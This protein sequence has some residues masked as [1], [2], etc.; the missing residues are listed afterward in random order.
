[1]KRLLIAVLISLLLP[2]I[3]YAD[4]TVKIAEPSHRGADGLFLDNQL[5][6]LVRAQGELRKLIRTSSASLVV[7]IATLEEIA[8]LADGYSYLNDA[9]ERVEVEKLTA[10]TNL[11]R[12]ISR[13]TKD[14]ETLILPYGNPDVDLFEN[15]PKDLEFYQQIAL[16]KASN[17]FTNFKLAPLV[18]DGVVSELPQSFYTTYRKELRALNVATTDPQVVTLRSELAKVL[19]PDLS[20]ASAGVLMSTLRY[21]IRE[22]EKRLRIVAGNYTI[23]ASKYDLPITVINEF[24][25]PITTELSVRSSNSR[26]RIGNVEPL[27]I[28]P[29]S[30]VQVEIPIE[31]IA[32]GQSRL[33]IKLTNSNGAQIGQSKSVELQLAVISP[34]TT[35]FTTGMAIILLLAAIVQSIRRVKRRKHE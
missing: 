14:K 20:E 1:V 4:T 13:L 9:E 30:Q 5:A 23:T 33:D 3:T 28:E 32:S 15:N 11:L 8:D 18:S 24:A 29:G 19:N 2:P 21:L 7:D 26:V 35:W 17:F 34:L 16:S 10:A 25:T 12:Q 22:N 27:L 31:V 6:N